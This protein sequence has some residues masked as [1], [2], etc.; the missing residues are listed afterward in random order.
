MEGDKWQEGDHDHNQS[1]S[2]MKGLPWE[3]KEVTMRNVPEPWTLW[4]H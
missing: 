3:A 2:G 4:P 1:W